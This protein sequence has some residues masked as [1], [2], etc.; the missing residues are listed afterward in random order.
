MALQ[1]S[2]C[3]SES[4]A[5]RRVNSRR[6]FLR[7]C[8]CSRSRNCGETPS[9]PAPKLGCAF[10]RDVQRIQVS[11][12]PDHRGDHQRGFGRTGSARASAARQP[13]GS[14]L[15]SQAQNCCNARILTHKFTHRE[16]FL[17]S[18]SATGSHH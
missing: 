17:Q 15:N 4:N 1:S 13:G 14:V 10:C 6:T 7:T 18:V 5:E 12:N 2:F 3:V 16:R 8:G 11:E 9:R